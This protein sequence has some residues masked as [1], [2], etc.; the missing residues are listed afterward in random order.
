MSG[1]VQLG[2]EFFTL[3]G[4]VYPFLFPEAGGV[5]GC[6]SVSPFAPKTA[7]GD[8]SYQDYEW[9]SATA[10][11]DLSGGMGQERLVDATQYYAS[12]NVDARGGRIVLGPLLTISSYAA[13]LDTHSGELLADTYAGAGAP[14]LDYYSVD[15]STTKLACKV[16]IP[17]GLTFLRRVW[18]PLR[19]TV[20]AGTVTVGIYAD[21][22]GSPGTLVDSITISRDEFKTWGGW[23]QAIFASEVSVIGGNTYW[24]S[25]EHSGAADS[26]AWYGAYGT[27]DYSAQANAQYWDGAAWVATAAYWHLIVL[28]DQD[29]LRLDAPTNLLLGAGEDGIT[30]LWGWGG[31]R[32]YYVN[33]ADD[34]LTLVTDGAGNA[35]ATVADIADAV[36]FR[37]SGDT[38]SLLYLALGD[39]TD[40]VKFDGNIGTEQW[41]AVTSIQ[42]RKLTVHN[43]L[44]WRCDVRNQ[45]SGSADGSTFGNAVAVGD[46]S[47]PVAKLLSWNGALYVGKQ[48]GL[49]K[50]E[51]VTGYP[52]STTPTCT[53]VLDFTSQVDSN[54]FSILLEHQGNLIFSIGQALLMYTLGNLLTPITP[55]SGL[56]LS[57]SERSYF[58]AGFSALSALWVCAEGPLGG[59]SALLAYVDGH[60]HA[61]ATMPRA[62][63]MLR[64]LY[65]EPGLYD[66]V[67]RLWFS[68]G[69]DFVYC[70]MPSTTQKRWLWDDMDW[71][72][73]GYLDTS[74]IDGGI[75]SINK[76]WYQVTLHVRDVA[77]WYTPPPVSYGPYVKVYWRPDEATAW[78]QVGAAVGTEGIVNLTFPAGSYGPK[79]QLRIYLYRGAL[80]IVETTPQVEAVVLKYIE[81]PEEYRTFTRTYEFSS[82]QTWRNGLPTGKTLAGWLADLALLRTSAE[83]LTL[84]TWYGAPY[85]GHI[86]DYD[87]K[88]IREQRGDLQDVGSLLAVIRFQELV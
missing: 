10:L 88:E 35:Y 8:R 1:S 85:T 4:V 51:Y 28:Y 38:Y 74:W 34:A 12:H 67:G 16:T 47:Y 27:D 64:S 81:R 69:L 68:S 57:V 50:V 19:A 25:V 29:S 24:I 2:D 87:V 46:T 41:S 62:G 40:M 14:E 52:T 77:I 18:L 61:L 15:S 54:N 72:A 58:R 42:A 21:D 48:D 49:Y 36:W 43:G 5:L 3:N 53:K 65:L 75:R 60:W 70:K 26:A 73:R 6:R 31:R 66:T 82:G 11:A 17:A 44:L 37:G 79:C 32:V 22:N 78:A 83:P 39:A 30:R 33:P 9:I 7:T 56:N 80:D 71:A 20:E 63:D 23:V 59:A 45:V 76:D 13:G 84:T 55:D 86:V